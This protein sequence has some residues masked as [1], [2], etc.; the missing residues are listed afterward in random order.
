MS[1]GS[2]F[3]L[4]IP[5]ERLAAGVRSEPPEVAPAV[6]QPPAGS[7]RTPV[8]EPKSVTQR[9]AAEPAAGFGTLDLFVQPVS[10]EVLIDGERWVTSEDGHF[11]VQVP[12]GKHRVE[13]RKPGYRRFAAEIEIRDGEIAPLNVSLHTT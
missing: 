3:S 1:P 4:R 8:T 6:P 7:Y 12:A 5:M 2:T 13:I 9:R 10:A 11:M